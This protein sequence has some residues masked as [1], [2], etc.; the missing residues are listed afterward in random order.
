M[1]VRFSYYHRTLAVYDR[2]FFGAKWVNVWA[3]QVINTLRFLQ[4][5]LLVFSEVREGRYD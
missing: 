5:M 3:V 1:T 2:F 4:V